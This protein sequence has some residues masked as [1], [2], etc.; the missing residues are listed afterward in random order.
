MGQTNKKFT[1]LDMEYD[2]E[3]S[4]EDPDWKPEMEGY[5]EEAILDDYY[6]STETEEDEPEPRDRGELHQTLERI[7]ETK[8]E[9]IKELKKIVEDMSTIIH[10][11]AVMYHSLLEDK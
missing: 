5:D 10:S 8:D 3:D 6:T 11:K 2:T 4:E 7:I 1:I 9:E